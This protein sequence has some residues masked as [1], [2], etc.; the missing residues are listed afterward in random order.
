MSRKYRRR[1]SEP[2]KIKSRS[3]LVILVYNERLECIGTCNTP[4]PNQMHNQNNVCCKW[5]SFG[6]LLVGPLYIAWNPRGV[7]TIV[8]NENLVVRRA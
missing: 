7:T 2:R 6:I 8:D 5:R 1:A 4:M 3:Y